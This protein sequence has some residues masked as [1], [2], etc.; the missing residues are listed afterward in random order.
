ML[1]ISNE[2]S[3][4]WITHVRDSTASQQK[5]AKDVLGSSVSKFCKSISNHTCQKLGAGGI[6]PAQ[7]N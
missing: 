7:N 2:F 5:K 3:D 1:F 4:F 6:K